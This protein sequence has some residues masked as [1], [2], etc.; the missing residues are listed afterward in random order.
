MHGKHIYTFL[1]KRRFWLGS[2]AKPYILISHTECGSRQMYVVSQ[3]SLDNTWLP[4]YS[5][6]KGF[7]TSDQIHK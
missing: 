2:S 1:Y 6:K 7:K 3:Y 4:I 5:I